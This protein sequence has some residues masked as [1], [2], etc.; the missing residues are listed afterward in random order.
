MSLTFAQVQAAQS[1]DLAGIAAVATEMDERVTRLAAQAARRISSHGDYREDFEQDARVAL[2]EAIPRY[3]GE[4]VDGFLG[5]LYASIQDALKDKARA[6]RY[7]GVDKDAVK[8][9]MAMLERAE[10]DAHKA[11]ALAQTEPVKGVRLSADRATAA[12][13][14]WQGAVSI[15]RP[16]GEDDD[17]SLLDTLAIEDETPT[18]VR[19]KV[20]RG[21]ALEA[22]SVLH[23][24]S[25][26]YAALKALPATSEDV[27]AIEDAVTLPREAFARK[28]VLDACAI[29]RSYVSTADEG[30]L[31]EELRDVSDERRDE[32][33][34]RIGMVRAAL[35]RMGEGQ[36]LVLVHSFGIGNVTAY[37]YGD[38]SDLAGLAAELG[39]TEA[40]AKVQ[41]SKARVA[42]AKYFI[43]LAAGTEAEA[44]ALAEAAAEMRKPGGRK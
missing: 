19:P 18:V 15:D 17:T 34:A 20:G 39:T 14:A 3:Q 43:A 22:L 23:R 36:R 10:G 42:F 35:D 41:R 28:A 38:G 9:F 40:N 7:Q 31:I 6:A 44:L 33:A 2:F 26:A 12:R 37:G 11:E 13:L 30:D 5:F 1:N 21:A 29:L 16:T 27:D 4:T 8:V 24:Y 32:R 25:T